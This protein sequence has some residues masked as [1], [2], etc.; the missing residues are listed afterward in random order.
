MARVSSGHDQQRAKQQ[1][2][3]SQLK[4][5]ATIKTERKEELKEEERVAVSVGYVLK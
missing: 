3:A 5:N 4:P 1:A 2:G